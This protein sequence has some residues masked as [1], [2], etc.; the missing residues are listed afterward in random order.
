MDV[1]DVGDVSIDSIEQTLLRRACAGDAAAYGDLTRLHR[2]AA[3]RVATV[4][5]GATDGADDV[6]Q[7]ALE[8]AWR[9]LDS[10]D[11]GRPFRPW[12]LRIVANSA[13]N[14][15]RGRGRHA[16][17]TTRAGV[18]ESRVTPL[19]PEEIAVDAEE[20]H[21][22]LEA[23]SSLGAA[24]RLVIALRHFEDLTE[25]E[26]A[27]VLGCRPGTVKSRLSRAMA[28]LRHRYLALAA[29]IAV[30]VLLATALVVAPAREAIADWLGIG[31]TRIE[32]VPDAEADAAD[33]TGLPHVDEALVA[34][35]DDELAEALDGRP[36]PDVDGT[37]LGAPDLV[38]LAPDTGVLFGWGEGRTTLWVQSG[39]GV[40]APEYW[41]TK[42]LR[43][44]VP[45][46]VVEG[47]GDDA[48]LIH[49]DHVLVSAGRTFDAARVLLWID[50]GFE[51][52]L[53]SD[54]DRAEML[55]VA[56]RISA[57]LG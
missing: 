2:P 30:A 19:T 52:R 9:S 3:L 57:A 50:G 56:Q 12:L 13:R 6:V 23:L 49:D 27:D 47:L 41:R 16:A 10:F 22:V 43:M 28:R 35:S 54:L 1:S 18:A 37:R 21:M 39:A 14:D 32:R 24:D 48:L 51:W 8:R 55:T 36:L 31:T 15:R 29:A 7:L 46:E 53:E 40:E 26:M 45:V 25:A 42:L 38:G 17:L 5:L 33:P 4:V 34:A 44:G 11:T 20:R